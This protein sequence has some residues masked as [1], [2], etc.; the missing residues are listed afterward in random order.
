MAGFSPAAAEALLAH[1]WVGNVRE[2]KNLVERAVLIGRGT[3]IDELTLGLT[4]LDSSN[5]GDGLPQGLPPLSG[6]GID[7]A[8]LLNS[9]ERFYIEEALKLAAHNESQAARLLGMN[10]HTFRYHRK[11]L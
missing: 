4:A 11:N 6:E 7:L 9:V 1:D 5:G 3:L 8:A 2:L 10:H